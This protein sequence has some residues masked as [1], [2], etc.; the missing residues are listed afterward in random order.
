MLVFH[1][2]ETK[3]QINIS[4]TLPSIDS[5]DMWVKLRLRTTDLIQL[6]ILQVWKL[7]LR[8]EGG[9][10]KGSSVLAILELRSQESGGEIPW[11]LQS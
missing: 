3:K 2:D 8:E 6:L 7:R 10:A 9:F 1:K 5:R 11:G 4:N